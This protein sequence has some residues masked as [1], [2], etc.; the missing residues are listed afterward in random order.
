MDYKT[1]RVGEDSS[2]RETANAHMQQLAYYAA[3]L[4]ALTGK[5]V[6]ERYVVL[7]TA[8]EAVLLEGA[9]P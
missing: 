9:T 1:D 6:K 8:R 5:P 7:L 2:P 4:A 3:A